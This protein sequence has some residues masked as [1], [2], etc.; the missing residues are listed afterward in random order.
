MV[1]FALNHW[2]TMVERSKSDS[3]IFSFGKNIYGINMTFSMSIFARFSSGFRN[4][5]TQL[6]GNNNVVTNF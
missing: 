2:H 5:S 6:S 3:G 1:F 4:D